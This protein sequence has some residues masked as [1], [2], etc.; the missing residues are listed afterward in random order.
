[1]NRFCSGSLQA[2]AFA[3]ASIRVGD[4]DVVLA[5]GGEHMNRVPLGSDRNDLE[6]LPITDAIREKYKIVPQGM[7]A[8]IISKKYGITQE[9]INAFSVG[10]QQKAHAATEAGKF[11]NE[12]IPIA[13]TDQ[14]GNPQ[15]L[16]RDSNIKPG[17]TPEKINALPRPFKEGG[18]ISCRRF[19]RNLRW[20][21]HGPVGVGGGSQRVRSQAEGSYSCQR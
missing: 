18:V 6:R 9:E 20:L 8:E 5:G 10:S 4:Y 21:L 7:S 11:K 15:V 14:D 3:N 12:I 2:S 1:M 13:Y 19:L 17:T 16:D